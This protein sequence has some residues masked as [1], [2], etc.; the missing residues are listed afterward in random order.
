MYY[1]S[2][3][4]KRIVPAIIAMVL[5]MPTYAQLNGTYTVGGTNPDYATVV[6]A[7]NDLNSNGV[8]GPV[9]FDIRQG[10]YTGQ[11]VINNISGASATNRITFQS[12]TGNPNDVI[13]NFGPNS[14]AS[15]YIIRLDDSRYITIKE[16]TVTT[17]VGSYG[18]LIE[19]RSNA[20]YN[21]IENCRL[22]AVGTSS[23]MAGIYGTSL[24]GTGNEIRNNYFN[25]GYY[26]IYF[27]GSSSSFSN[28]TKST[29]IENNTF[30]EVWYYSNYLYYQYELK[31]TDN[32]IK[33]TGTGTHYGA[34]IYY[35]DYCDVSGNDISF[36][37]S[38]TRY[39]FYCYYNDGGINVSNNKIV[40]SGT[41][42]KYGMRNRYNYGTSGNNNTIINNVIAIDNG[43]STAYGMYDYYARYQLIANNTISIN[44]T[45]TGSQAARF[46]YT[47]NS[48]RY[49]T[50]RNNVF[51]NFGSG[52]AMYVYRVN[53]N[54]T[55]DYNNIYSKG[56]NMIERGSPSGSYKTLEAWRNATDQDWHSINY[57]PGFKGILDP[58][59]DPANS[60][61]WSLNGRAIHISGNNK[62][63]N[64]NARVEQRAD[65]VPDIGAYEFDPSVAPPLATA[66][67]ASAT[68]G[69]TQE[70]YF[71]ENLVGTVK[72]STAYKITAPIEVRQYSGR[73]APSFNFNDFMYFYT[74]IQHKGSG[75]TYN[76]DADVQYMDIWLGT[77][78][79]EADV[80]LAHKFGN[81]SWTAYNDNRSSVN[82]NTNTI[83][84][85]T[86]TSFGAFTG[87]LNGEI[88]STDIKPGS[89]T[90]ICYGGQVVLTANGNAGY[91][92][93]WKL[94]GSDISG[95]TS[96]T[97]TASTPGDY[98]VEVTDNNNNT[99]VSIPVTVAA[100]APPNA[101]VATS[102]NPI[103]CVG[104]GLTLSTQQGANL[105]YQWQL[106]GNNIPGATND[107]YTVNSA[108]EYTVVVENLA[109]ATVSAPQK[110]DAGPLNV[111][112]GMDLSVCE[113]KDLPII[114]DAGYPGATYTW[115]T[116]DA[117]QQVVIN[118]TGQ[119]WVRV[120]AGPNCIDIDTI[121]VEVTPLP[122]ANGI[123]YVRNGSSY[124][125]SPSN[126]VNTTG[127][128][129]IFS[130]GSTSTQQFVTKTING[131]VY[132]RLVL[133]NQCGT[134]TVQ[135]G[136]KLG[137]P[138][139]A[140]ANNI[141]VYPN[142]A[143][144]V[145]NIR[146]AQPLTNNVDLNIINNTGSV[147]H[148]QQLQKGSEEQTV[149]VS[150]LPAGYYMIRMQSADAVVTKPINILR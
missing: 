90:L 17:T 35:S 93:Q 51:A 111:D 7:A 127:Y 25:R 79:N 11:V 69:R 9:T 50:V 145:V 3:L 149:N 19:F 47:S 37:G 21:H 60:A 120:D 95:A 62:D 65:G 115:S 130:D 6:A 36:D 147:V 89:S 42:T 82:V 44:S 121:N 10:T 129:W 15:N 71:G 68:P 34:R 29:V 48:Y 74:D 123:S 136:Y 100:I 98:T 67:P 109:C 22:L 63:M 33:R 142:P 20:S 91:K 133:Y 40:I 2:L 131:D 132:V 28:S 56:T 45:S 88:F 150:A 70:F 122:T 113:Q 118:K 12:E 112:L 105:T 78:S 14:T 38:A 144:D 61:S 116:G 106:N 96:Q 117:S 125:F 13:I 76:F 23:R 66:V 43:T 86:I 52:D 59:P 84:V 46:Y 49:N 58:E 27:R 140:D 94:N 143:K 32:I 24:R 137:I 83:Q 73:K 108:G 64:G 97:Y 87:T 26:G 1:T 39:G 75:N 103:Y 80:R 114:L 119:Y 55:W 135:L 31:L 102:S 134:D 54:N 92:Y 107:M 141:N 139:L 16:I 41:G 101:P 77:M 8:S 4:I 72:W 18:R 138:E 148:S 85:N 104:N 124:T 57:D 126:P 110:V 53:Y 81:N 5:F 30:D 99:A 146:F 128:M